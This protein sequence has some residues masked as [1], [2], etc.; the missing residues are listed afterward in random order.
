MPHNENDVSSKTTHGNTS[1]VVRFVKKLLQFD[2]SHRPA[3]YDTWREKRYVPFDIMSD[4]IDY[5]ILILLVF[6]A[7]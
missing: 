4:Y 3:Y 2:K 6:C 1:S 5:F 7:I